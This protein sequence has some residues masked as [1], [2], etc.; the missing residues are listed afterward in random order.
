MNPEVKALWLKALRSGKYQQ[1]REKL[2]D[3]NGYC[4]LGVLCDL[5]AKTHFNRWRKQQAWADD[6]HYTLLKEDG[7]LPYQVKE[8]AGLPASDPAVTSTEGA[9]DTLAHLNDNGY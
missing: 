9:A 5:Y 1:T 2:R 7:E 8:W 6:I 4:C 3:E